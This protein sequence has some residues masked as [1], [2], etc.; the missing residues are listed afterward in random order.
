MRRMY[1]PL[2]AFTFLFALCEFPIIG[3]A[4]YAIDYYDIRLY[5][6]VCSNQEPNLE[7]KMLIEK[8][9]AY[10]IP[11]LN[12][13]FA[14]Y[15]LRWRY[16]NIEEVEIDYTIDSGTNLPSNLDKTVSLIREKS[17]SFSS[18]CEQ[19]EVVIFVFAGK[20]KGAYS[21][22][23]HSPIYASEGMFQD[24]SHSLTL[25]EHEIMHTFNLPD[26]NFPHLKPEYDECV[27][28]K[29]DLGQIKLCTECQKRLFR[30]FIN[31][32]TNKA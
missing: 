32:N 10:A 11:R 3:N 4:Y 22:D 1:M 30:Y 19:Y 14:T 21:Y 17:Q 24:E 26:H 23:Y 7:W 31:R 13:F 18:D 29:L 20:F 27:M 15:G 5:Y 25:I 6:V 8:A 16:T 12:L 9:M 28:G 2:I